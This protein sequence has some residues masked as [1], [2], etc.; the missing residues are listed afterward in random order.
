MNCATEKNGT[1]QE[2]QG[3]L[4]LNFDTENIEN[5]SIEFSE[6]KDALKVYNSLLNAENVYN[7]HL[8]D[9]KENLII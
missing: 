9:S 4:H 3:N 6:F 7:L 1:L 5:I 2:I 8:K